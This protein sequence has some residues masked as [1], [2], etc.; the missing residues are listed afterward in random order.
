MVISSAMNAGNTVM[1]AIFMAGALLTILYL[2]RLFSRV[3]LGE[4]RGGEPAA[5][6]SPLMVT[7]VAILA[8]LS[9]AGGLLVGWPAAFAQVAVRLMPGV[10]Q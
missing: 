8:A 6:K 2:M 1:A 5:E 9:L 10:T 7:C 4:S 3:F